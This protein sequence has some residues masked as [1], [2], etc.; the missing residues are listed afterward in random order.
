MARTFRIRHLPS[1]PGTARRF[2]F[3]HSNAWLEKDKLILALVKRLAPGIPV[4]TYYDG[5][6]AYIQHD[7]IRGLIET[8]EKQIVV[9]LLSPHFHPWIRSRGINLRTA[10][11]YRKRAHR[12]IRHRSKQ[13]LNHSPIDPDELL[14]PA[15]HEHWNSWNIN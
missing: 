12:T 9:P 3:T 13:L 14:M 5:R 10:R 1:L 8:L 6:V 4:R 11:Y 7:D 15:W 2:A